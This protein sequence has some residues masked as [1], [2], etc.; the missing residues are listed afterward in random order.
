VA[1]PIWKTAYRLQ[2]GAGDRGRLQGWA[3]L[4]NTS[5]RDWNGVELTLLSGNP[6]TFRQPLYQAYYVE[7]PLLPVET[8]NRLL[9]LIDPG[10]LT[11]RRQAPM[12]AMRQSIMSNASNMAAQWNAKRDQ[13][14]AE[15]SSVDE[16]E[17]ASLSTA[18]ASE[19]QGQILLT[20][21]GKQTITSG[22]SLMTPIIDL[23]I[24]AARHTLLDGVKPM[25]AVEVVNTGKTGLPPGAIAFYDQTAAS[26]YLGDGRIGALPPG[27]KRLVGFAAD[28]NVRILRE[29]QQEIERRSAVIADNVVRVRNQV[30]VLTLYRLKSSAPE[31]RIVVIDAPRSPGVELVEPAAT[32]ASVSLIPNGYRIR[33]LLEPG[34]EDSLRVTTQQVRQESLDFNALLRFNASALG[35]YAYNVIQNGE[36]DA[37]TK[38]I[39]EQIVKLRRASLETEAQIDAA[40]E[41]RKEI[42]SEQKRLRDNM[43]HIPSGSDLEKRY[44]KQMAQQEDRLVELLDKVEELRARKNKADAELRAWLSSESRK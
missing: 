34:K 11:V 19:S 14:T 15:E 27:E 7:R 18:G 36:I 12:P 43:S 32:D 22:Q 4:E 21:S 26:S 13:E 44:L 6:V 1:T 8:P 31:K 38:A 40:N 28:L 25:V 16:P 20:L 41:S 24:P 5:G 30:R 35:N 2:L 10:E 29:P 37:E 23:E 33:Y 9:P 17:D 42:I 39:F 3:I